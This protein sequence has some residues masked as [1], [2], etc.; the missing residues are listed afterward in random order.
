VLVPGAWP[1]TFTLK[2]LVRRGNDTGPRRPS[3]DLAMWLARVGD[4]RVQSEP[5]SDADVD[6]VD[7][8]MG[9]P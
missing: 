5:L 3:E 6:D 4:G 9:G 1:Q 7:D 8:S 2:E